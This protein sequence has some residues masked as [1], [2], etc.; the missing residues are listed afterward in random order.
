MNNNTAQT[1]EGG[2]GI[3]TFRCEV[4]VPSVPAIKKGGPQA[5]YLWCGVQEKTDFGVLQ[6]VLM[7]GPDCVQKLPEGEKSGPDND[8]DYNRNPYWYYSAQY[9]FPDP[10]SPDGYKCTTGTVL[11]AVPGE[12]LVS[13]MAYDAA[14]DEMTVRISRPDGSGESS[15]TVKHPKGDPSKHWSDFIGM[16]EIRLVGALEIP[17][18]ETKPPVPPEILKGFLLK[19]TVTPLPS[20]PIAGTHAWQLEPNE[21]NTLSVDCT[22]NASTLG[23]DCIWKKRKP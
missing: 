22:H 20:F 5:I 9:V 14:K 4:S 17:H 11:K 12:T 3:Q 18:P 16:D 1:V 23:S 21:A 8:P 7:F 2:P 10:P 6:P 19:A 13:I 15:L